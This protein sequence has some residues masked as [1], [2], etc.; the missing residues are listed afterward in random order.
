MTLAEFLAAV[1]RLHAVDREAFLASGVK[2]PAANWPAFK[3]NPATW[4]H[5]AREADPEGVEKLWASLGETPA[6]AEPEPLPY[7]EF[8]D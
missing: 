3:H 5:L 7:A 2:S 8:D 6:P 4:L 1:D